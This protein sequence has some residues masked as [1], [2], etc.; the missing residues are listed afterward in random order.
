MRRRGL[1]A[2]AA[3]T[4]VS[5]PADAAELD[6][7][8]VSDR[9]SRFFAADSLD[10]DGRLRLATGV[11]STYEHALR[12]FGTK[13]EGASTTLVSDQLALH[14]GA[15]VIMAPGVRFALDMPFYFQHGKQQALA[16]VVYPAPR[17]PVLGDLRFSVDLKLLGPPPGQRD[18]VTLAGG[19]WVWLP[20]GSPDDYVSDGYARVGLRVGASARSGHVL[21]AGRLGI[22]YRRDDLDPLGGVA[23]GSDLSAVAAVGWVEGALTVGPELHATTILR[24]DVF[25][26]RATPID[27]LVGAHLGVADFM[28]G[29]G[30][31]TAIDKGIGAPGF[32]G[33]LAI[34]WL[35]KAASPSAD[36]DRDGVPDAEDVCPDVPGLRDGPPESRGCP[37]APRDGDRDG[38][39]D[40]EDACPDLPGVRTRDPMTNGCPDRDRD[41]VPDPVDACPDTPG[42]RSDVPRENGCPPDADGDEVPDDADA[43]PDQPGPASSDAAKNGC[44]APPP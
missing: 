17:S 12:A 31:G 21:A 40:A 20:T 19:V 1:F 8:E 33:L 35:P 23:L 11:V 6:R 29:A 27:G 25:G 44:P 41:G 42:E 24:D 36:R 39:P 43:C 2:A 13:Q 14:A 16:G 37:D 34:E 32:R 22:A 26:S 3:A 18:G 15:G 5:L 28:L 38:I 10:L 7:F 4:F 9:G 30:V